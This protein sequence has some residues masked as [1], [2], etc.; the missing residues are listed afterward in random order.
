MRYLEKFPGTRDYLAD[1]Q[2]KNYLA[3][4]DRIAAV[5]KDRLAEN[6]A[7]LKPTNPDYEEDLDKAQG[8]VDK[9]A[10]WAKE[11]KLYWAF[12][13]LYWVESTSLPYWYAQYIGGGLSGSL[14][15]QIKKLNSIFSTVEDG[16]VNTTE[17]GRSFMQALM[18]RLGFSK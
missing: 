17:G 6:S 1:Q 2:N 14:G 13:A 18:K 12:M 16:Q 11:K 5:L 8:D 4:I 15:R 9:L 3:E 7:D 10:T